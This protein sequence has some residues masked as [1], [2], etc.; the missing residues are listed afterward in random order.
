MFGL[1]AY[2]TPVRRLFFDIPT[3]K[4]KS[5]IIARQALVAFHDFWRYRHLG[6]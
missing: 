5:L 6:C 2:P 3:N 1:K 4:M